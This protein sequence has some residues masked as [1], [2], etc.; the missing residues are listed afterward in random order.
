MSMVMIV[1]KKAL[2]EDDRIVVYLKVYT[3]N[4]Y[5]ITN[6]EYEV[7]CTGYLTYDIVMDI[8]IIF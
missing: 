7:Q 8:C 6:Y 2:F 5:L 4:R 3:K 1:L